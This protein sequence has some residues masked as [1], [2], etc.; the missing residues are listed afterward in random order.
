MTNRLDKMK[1]NQFNI[2][3]K[4]NLFCNQDEFEINEMD[5]DLYNESIND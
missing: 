1:I 4:V 2:I 3:F 5:E